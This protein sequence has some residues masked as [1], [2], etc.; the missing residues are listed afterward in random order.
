MLG[1]RGSADADGDCLNETKTT[2][3]FIFK[4]IL[5]QGT[6]L[7][8]VSDPCCSSVP[9][10]FEQFYQDYFSH[11]RSMDLGMALAVTLLDWLLHHFGPD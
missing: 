6:L 8:I 3:C 2:I 11:I 10:N 7:G 1:K 5:S 4:C 9:Y